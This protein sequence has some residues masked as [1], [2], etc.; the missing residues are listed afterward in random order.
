MSTAAQITDAV[1]AALYFVNYTGYNQLNFCWA[2]DIIE[3]EIT[4]EDREKVCPQLAASARILA[5][6]VVRLREKQQP[7]NITISYC[8]EAPAVVAGKP[9]STQ[10]YV[11]PECCEPCDVFKTTT[12]HKHNE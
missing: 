2:C 5:D 9:G 10:W 4:D 11:C 7:Q 8:C 12:T 3:R 6:E 1:Q